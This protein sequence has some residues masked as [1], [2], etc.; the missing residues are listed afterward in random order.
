M[1]ECDQI[2]RLGVAGQLGEVIDVL[3]TTT[4]R[5]GDRGTAFY[6]EDLSV[7]RSIPDQ[8]VLGLV[9]RSVSVAPRGLA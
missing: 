3:E 1:L 4:D 9:L 6:P 5:Q 7:H 2:R 8:P